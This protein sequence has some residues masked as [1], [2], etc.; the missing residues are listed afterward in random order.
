MVT[1]I[2]RMRGGHPRREDFQCVAETFP[3]AWESAAR[4]LGVDATTL[5]EFLEQGTLSREKVL[6]TF[7]KELRESLG[8][9]DEATNNDKETKAWR[10]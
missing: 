1:M 6:A 2:D 5:A 7:V 10:T 8:I 9:P 4:Q 3:Q